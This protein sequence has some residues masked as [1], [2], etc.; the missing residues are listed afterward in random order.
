[1]KE[2]KK[3]RNQ[4]QGESIAEIVLTYLPQYSFNASELRWLPKKVINTFFF[5]IDIA[6]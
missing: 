1:L 6:D 5:S 4:A 2:N 3:R